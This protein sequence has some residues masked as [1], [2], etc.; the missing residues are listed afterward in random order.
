MKLDLVNVYLNLHD[1]TNSLCI[2]Q[3]TIKQTE[4]I[5]HLNGKNFKKHTKTGYVEFSGSQLDS[6]LFRGG[7]TGSKKHPRRRKFL[8]D[9]LAVGSLIY[10]W[11]WALYSRRNEYRSFPL[12]SNPYLENIGIE[13]DKLQKCFQGAI[14]KIKEPAWQVQ[15]ENGFHLRMCLNHANITN[16][17]SRF[18][19]NVV[20][21][22]WL[23]PHLKNPHGATSKDESYKLNEIINFVLK[24]FWPSVK[25]DGETI[26]YVLRN[27]LAHSGRLP[28]SEDRCKDAKWM[29]DL[30]VE[31]ENGKPGINNYMLFFGQLTQVIVLKTLG[32]DADKIAP[33]LQNFLNLGNI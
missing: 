15:Y 9:I 24:K 2:D 13:R 32:I 8:D 18:L 12:I 29:S 31:F 33:Q 10:G 17:E 1:E 28:I 16:T 19:S 11:N 21:W 3:Y 27:Q 25:L 7:I 22:E 5:S 30:T 4:Y 23:Y 20:I 6:V 26:F 14:N